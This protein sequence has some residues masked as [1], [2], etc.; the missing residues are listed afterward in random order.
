MIGL[1][2]NP[3]TA[4]DRHYRRSNASLCTSTFTCTFFRAELWM[5]KSNRSAVFYPSHVIRTAY[6][7]Y[8]DVRE[9]QVLDII[10]DLRM[11]FQM[12]LPPEGRCLSPRPTLA[13][14]RNEKYGSPKAPDGRE[15][16]NRAIA[17]SLSGLGIWDRPG[18]P[19]IDGQQTVTN[20]V[21]QGMSD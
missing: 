19:S 16:P 12:A 1:A 21:G 20:P 11:S 2:F 14:G 8:S 17:G 18:I 3:Q 4:G 5:W 7:R 10:H 9:E 13:I 6:P 15:L